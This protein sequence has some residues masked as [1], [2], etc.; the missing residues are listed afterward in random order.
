MA[1]LPNDSRFSRDSRCALTVLGK[2]RVMLIFLRCSAFAVLAAL[3]GCASPEASRYY[4]L[5]DPHAMAAS[6]VQAGTRSAGYVISVQAVTL[7]QA[8]DRPQ[9]VVADSRSEQLHPLATY[10]WAAPLADEIRTVLSRTLQSELGV[11]DVP[12]GR[13]PANL[14]AW[15]ITVNIQRFDSVYNDHALVDATWTLSPV[16][17]QGATTQVCGAS[18]SVPAGQGVAALV[19]SHRKALQVLGKLIASR[20]QA[21]HGLEYDGLLDRGCTSAK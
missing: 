17:L 7:P 14:P 9:I 5:A 13:M 15:K 20:A 4:S 1:G 3:A 12:A 16:N 8:V 18:M 6:S 11:F 21:G 2:P 19:A 10:V